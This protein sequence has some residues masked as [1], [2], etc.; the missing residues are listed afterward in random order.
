MLENNVRKCRKHHHS[1]LHETEPPD[2]KHPQ[3]NKSQT[4]PVLVSSH[5]KSNFYLQVI[6]IILSNGS[7]KAKTNA[8]F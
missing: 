2:K 4:L 6:P 8:L 7:F 3:E 1:L 5:H